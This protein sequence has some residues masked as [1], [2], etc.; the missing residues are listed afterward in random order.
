MTEIAASP[1]VALRRPRLV[2]V[3]FLCYAIFG[4][5]S[6]VVRLE[7]FL[8]LAKVGTMSTGEQLFEIGVHALNI[9]AATS[10]W[11]LRRVAFPLFSLCLLLNLGTGTWHWLPGGT[12]SN[13]FARGGIMAGAIVLGACTGVLLALGMWWYVFQLW[14]R[15]V[16]R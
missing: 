11:L 5:F 12:D 9:V 8:G 6:L 2:W 10:L 14:R 13:V 16:L 15:G 3:I 4:G 7:M 1:P